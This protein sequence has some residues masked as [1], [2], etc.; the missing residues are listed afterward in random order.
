MKKILW[1]LVL[2]F[3]TLNG[4]SAKFI[5][6]NLAMKE[7]ERPKDAQIRYGE[8]YVEKINDD[9]ENKYLYNDTIISLNCSFSPKTINFVIHNKTEYP[10]K[11]IWDEVAYINEEGQTTRVIHSG[12]RLID[13]YNPQV[14]SI[15]AP[16]TE[17]SETLLPVENIYYLNE[18]RYDYLF[19]QPHRDKPIKYE[20]I[21]DP[22]IGKRVSILLPF[23]IEGIINDYI[24]IFEI[25]DW[26]IIKVR[27][28]T[29]F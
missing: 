13:R 27:G 14:P 19:P 11:I 12:I 2:S 4:C 9:S 3:M 23:E 21:A 10:I 26:E 17:I 18:W 16:K 6:Y 20:L 5:Q 1:I 8:I 15:I 29:W 24:F 7:I 22:Q 28:I 25:E